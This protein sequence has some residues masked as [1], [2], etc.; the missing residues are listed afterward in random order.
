M[1]IYISIAAVLAL[2]AAV[3]AKGTATIR[4]HQQP[5]PIKVPSISA[6]C[7][8]TAF[9][10][11]SSRSNRSMELAK[12]VAAVVPLPTVSAAA[13]GVVVVT[14]AVAGTGPHRIGDVRTFSGYQ[15]AV[16]ASY[17]EHHGYQF[18][19]V[20][21]TNL[22]QFVQGEPSATE[23]SIGFEEV[24]ERWYK[25]HLLLQAMDRWAA[26]ATAFVWI[27]KLIADSADSAV[28]FRN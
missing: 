19:S 10:D 11:S 26:A 13:G 23:P 24:D 28:L 6:C 22:Q 20:N 1:S 25:I 15:S 12:C 21:D 3:V 17:A 2:S 18:L 14:M 9:S 7:A 16:V 4:Q 27:G 5:W 8:S